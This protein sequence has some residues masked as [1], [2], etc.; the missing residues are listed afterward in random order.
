MFSS[1]EPPTGH[2]LMS[3]LLAFL[4]I[5]Y[6]N[7]LLPMSKTESIPV[8]RRESEA[9]DIAAYTVRCGC[10]LK[11]QSERQWEGGKVGVLTL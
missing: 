6:S 8:A 5:R 4:W 3:M 7:T 9:E 1:L 11:Y 10:E 2:L